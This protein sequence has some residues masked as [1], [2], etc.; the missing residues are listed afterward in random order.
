MMNKWAWIMRIFYILVLLLLILV[1]RAHGDGL[2]WW[3]IGYKCCS[4][5]ACAKQRMHTRVV[6]QEAR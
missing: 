6:V 2:R 3:R 5:D 1:L 4:A